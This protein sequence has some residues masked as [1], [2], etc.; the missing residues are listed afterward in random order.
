MSAVCA[1]P[2]SYSCNRAC[3]YPRASTG[4]SG[5][6]VL[7]ALGLSVGALQTCRAERFVKLLSQAIGCQ[8]AVMVMASGN[9]AA[10]D[11]GHAGEDSP[12][13]NAPGL[14][15]RAG[16]RADHCGALCGGAGADPC[17]RLV[18]I[19]ARGW[20]VIRSSKLPGIALLIARPGN[21]AAGQ[22]AAYLHAVLARSGRNLPLCRRASRHRIADCRLSDAGK[23]DGCDRAGGG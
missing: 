18:P 23:R 15:Y 20:L 21:L 6:A 4:C 1:C 9:S 12:Q 10:G 17:R 13:V 8:N 5:P 22:P 3:C 11:L 14:G 7:F 16:C 19:L 2:G